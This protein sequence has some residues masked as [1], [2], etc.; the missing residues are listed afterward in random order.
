MRSLLARTSMVYRQ[1]V[2]MCMTVAPHRDRSG[3][4][5]AG[6]DHEESPSI[7]SGSPSA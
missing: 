7:A 1:A 6:S 5:G 3:P 4:S 2:R